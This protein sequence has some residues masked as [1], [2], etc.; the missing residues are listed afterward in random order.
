MINSS[1]GKNERTKKINFVHVN[2]AKAWDC[3]VMIQLKVLIKYVSNKLV[4]NVTLT[5]IRLN[6]KTRLANL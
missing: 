4:T 6:N 3:I 2:V 5:L 1:Q